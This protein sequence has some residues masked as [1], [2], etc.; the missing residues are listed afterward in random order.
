MQS[1]GHLL[2][3]IS[4]LLPLALWALERSRRQRWSSAWL[5]VSLAA[6]A[7]IPLSGEVHLALGAIPF[8]AAYALV[9]TRDPWT[10]AGAGLAVAAAVAGGLVIQRYTIA[11]TIG[12]GERSLH[13]VSAYSATWLDFLVRHERHGSESFVFLG[14]ATPLAA[15]AGLAALAIRRRY[16]LLVVLGLGA[17]LPMLL[18]LGTTTPVYGWLRAILPPLRYPRVPERMMPV[19]CLALAALVAFAIQALLDSSARLRLSPA[20]RTRLVAAIAIVALLADLH[21]TVFGASAADASNRA[22]STLAHDPP[23]ARLLELPLFAP[24]VP[25]G[26]V[27]LYYDMQARRQR[28]GGYSTIAPRSA[29]SVLRQLEPLDC[30]DWTTRP[31]RLLRKL[32]VADITFNLGLYTLNPFVPDRRWFAWRGLVDHGYR[33]VVRDGAA[34]LLDR[35]HGGPRPTSPVRE[36]ARDGAKYCQGWYPNDGDGRAMSAAHA[37]L[38]VY[39]SGAVRLFMRAASPLR[40]RFSVDGRPELTHVVIRT[41]HE[42]RVPL[43]SP[44][45]HLITLDSRLPLIDGRPEGARVVAYALG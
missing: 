32:G 10:L 29:A 28:P 26:S 18:G 37:G 38:W 12:A 2:G 40:V 41:L 33:P 45:W 27:Y 42:V 7:S 35:R 14:W 31:D 13:D 1:T 24:D 21:V 43:G 11:G 39:G 44:A 17:L 22:Y 16:G 5:V 20:R 9:R 34:I 8:Y 15:L 19:A 4:L 30:G 25:Y 3:P 36:P 6:L 23:D